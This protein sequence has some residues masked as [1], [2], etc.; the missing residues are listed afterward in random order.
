[1]N[2]TSWLLGGKYPWRSVDPTTERAGSGSSAIAS[3]AGLA[4]AALAEGPFGLQS[5]DGSLG[6]LTLPL[7]VAVDGEAVLVLSH[8]RS[9]VFRYDPVSMTLAPLPEIGR[10]GLGD[11]ASDTEYL[12]A[13]RF[14][15]AANIAAVDGALYVADVDARRVQVF[16]L[17]T[18][19][20]VRIHAGLGLPTDVAAGRHAAYVLDKARGVIYRASPDRDDLVLAVDSGKKWKGW[21]RIAVD[22]DGR[23]YALDDSQSPPVLE[24]FDVRGAGPATAPVATLRD[25]AEARKEF[26]EPQ[27]WFSRGGFELSD[28]LADPCGLRKPNPNV[29]RW[30]ADNRIYT[31][32][33]ETRE[34]RVL[35]PDGRVRH[36]FGPFDARGSDVPADAESAWIPADVA[37]T[38]GCVLILDERHQA[39]YS[40]HRGNET[41]RRRFAG[42]S[43]SPAKWRR[44]A[45]DDGTCV[46]LWDGISAYVDKFDLRGRSLGKVPARDAKRHFASAEDGAADKPAGPFRLTR[47][48]T[49]LVGAALGPVTIDLAFEKSAVWMTKWLDSD[50]Y[51]CQWHLIE[52]SMATL[53]PGS[54]V[55]VKTR[56]S[57]E[58]QDD[59]DALAALPQARAA[60]SWR[61]TEAIAGPAQSGD[62]EKPPRVDVLVQSGPGQYLQLQVELTG[63]G[64]TTPVIDSIRLR[65]PRESLLEYL[66]AIYS[67]PEDQ[68]AFLD[69]FL[70]IAQTTWSAIE[71]EVE[72]FERF[73]DADSVPPSALEY[74]ASWLDLPLE[75]T[76]K[77]DEKRKLLRAMPRLRATWGTV[78]A[79]AAWLRVYLSKLSGVDEPS[80]ETASIPQI[81]ESFVERRRL[82]LGDPASTTLP[83]AHGLWSPSV[84]RR[85]QVGVFDVEGEIE[86]VSVGDPD[87]DVFTHYAHSFRIFMPAA[88]VRTPED[89]AMIRRA[90]D[91]QKPAHTTYELVLIEPRFRVGE[92]STIGLDTVIGGPLP[93]ALVCSDVVDAPSRPP[94]QRLGF[95]TTVGCGDRRSDRTIE[96]ILT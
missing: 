26:S 80:L 20:L 73:L 31:I 39:V 30:K 40:H 41:L 88:W 43:D 60:G 72:T 27:V 24:V 10:H 17:E 86:L 92:Q 59:A 15:N 78:D 14:R 53:P 19:A 32:D 16:D 56:T 6:R 71:E 67:Q 47:D 93:G 68:R 23:I 35:L 46:L 83:A 87:V 13:R 37:E 21:S 44:I 64:F 8:D 82:M 76:W 69:R 36:R 51:N 58:K 79:M 5:K 11:D 7:G 12:E 75:A 25:R 3:R 52:V 55:V 96:R 1:M 38:D 50:I 74:L 70:S 33:R 34:V 61:A 65:F 90:I 62:P 85:F 81:V 29:R 28:R 42:P 4:L 49:V 91:Q 89:E 57:N 45:V 94:S 48:G 54:R 18:L 2:G 9:L 66:P 63:S 22:D 77:P 95:D 84:E